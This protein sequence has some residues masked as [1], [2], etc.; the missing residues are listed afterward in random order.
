MCVKLILLISSQS[1]KWQNIYSFIE[2]NIQRKIIII[3]V[4]LNSVH[5]QRFFS[6]SLTRKTFPNGSTI[7][8]C[9]LPWRFSHSQTHTKIDRPTVDY[10]SKCTGK[11]EGEAAKPLPGWI[12]VTEPLIKPLSSKAL[13]KYLSFLSQVDTVLAGHTAVFCTAGREHVPVSGRLLC[14]TPTATPPPHTH[15]YLPSSINPPRGQY[16]Y[17][18]P[19]S[20]L[21]RKSSSVVCK[22]LQLLIFWWKS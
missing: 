10:S 18:Y 22:S 2:N 12:E 20:F 15:L 1:L 13:I 9:P 5:L 16:F 17:S 14:V 3:K 7:I 21:P 8:L 6:S 11:P 4:I 19:K